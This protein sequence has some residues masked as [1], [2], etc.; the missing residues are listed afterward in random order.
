MSNKISPNDFEIAKVDKKNFKHSTIK[1]SN[2]TNEFTIGEIEDDMFKLN[3]LERE[4][5][6]QVKISTA[7]ID[8]IKRNHTYVS[9]MTDEMLRTAAYLYE[10]KKVMEQAAKKLR[11]VKNQKKKY[12]EVKSVIYAKFG[13]KDEESK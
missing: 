4:M 11:E 10:T 8:N 6:A 2:L 1:R 7:A 9:K 5:S 13:F 12:E 3:T